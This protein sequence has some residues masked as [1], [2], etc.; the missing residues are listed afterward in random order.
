MIIEQSA[1]VVESNLPESKAMGMKASAKAYDILSSVIYSRKEEAI[2]RELSCNAYD[3]HVAAGK[4]DVPFEVHLPTVLEPWLAIRDYGVGLTAEGIINTF[5]VFFESTKEKSNDFVGAMGIGSKSPLAYTDTYTVTGYKDGKKSSCVIYKDNDGIPYPTIL[6]EEDSD[7][8]TGVEVKLAIKREDFSLFIRSAEKVFSVFEIKPSFTGVVLDLQDLYKCNLI[9]NDNVF[10]RTTDCVRYSGIVRVIMGNIAYPIDLDKLDA[11]LVKP[12][13][14]A[15][16][17][18]VVAMGTVSFSASRESLKYDV[19]TIQNLTTIFGEIRANVI[20][21]VKSVT[22][23]MTK[24]ESAILFASQPRIINMISDEFCNTIDFK[25]N[26]EQLSAYMFRHN[27]RSDTFVQTRYFHGTVGSNYTNTIYPETTTVYVNDSNTNYVNRVK[28]AHPNKNDIL[29]ITAP[30]KLNPVELDEYQEFLDSLGNPPVTMVSSLPALPK[31]TRKPSTI[32]KNYRCFETTTYL[33]H[34]DTHTVDYKDD[35]SVQ[36]Y[37][38]CS[39][40]D[41]VDKNGTAIYKNVT[42]FHLGKMARLLL[43]QEVVKV[44]FSRFKEIPDNWICV[45]DTWNE[46]V[47]NNSDSIRE[48]TIKSKFSRMASMM[49]ILPSSSKLHSMIGVKNEGMTVAEIIIGNFVRFSG[50]AGQFADE[51]ESISAAIKER[52]PLL[53]VIFSSVSESQI[54]E[55]ITMVDAFKS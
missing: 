45:W 34:A 48:V 55:Y 15:S 7:E 14:Y 27:L 5:S 42:D 24:W 39:K 46:W 35:D 11:N 16:I 19:K 26:S 51:V 40:H 1:T 23:T 33:K 8:P 49:Q 32:G 43:G 29:I 13:R 4:K 50:D 44:P 18:I 10:V 20:K 28:K 37:T 30:D 9:G 22:E 2:I 38:L 31:K 3:S 54:V 6:G 21:G 25:N 17:D 47:A 41:Y 53:D 12:F 52:Y 36:Y